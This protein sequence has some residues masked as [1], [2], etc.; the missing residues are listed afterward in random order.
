[1]CGC[2][3]GG[4]LWVGMRGVEC[5]VRDMGVVMKVEC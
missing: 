2:V 4:V 3:S 1:M 5:C